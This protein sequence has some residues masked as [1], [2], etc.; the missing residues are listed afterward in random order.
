MGIMVDPGIR[1]LL[2]HGHRVGVMRAYV[3]MKI[4]PVL[5]N[6]VSLLLGRV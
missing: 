5:L 2:C 3:V 6:L 1:R 4:F